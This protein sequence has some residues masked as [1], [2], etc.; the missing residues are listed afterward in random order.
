MFFKYHTHGN[1]TQLTIAIPHPRIPDAGSIN[2]SGTSKHS[3]TPVKI[4]FTVS[5]SSLVACDPCTRT[6]PPWPTEQAM[7][8]I[9]RIILVPAGKYFKYIKHREH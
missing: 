5:T 1:V 4:D 8:G 2:R 3:P 6:T 7:L 9:I